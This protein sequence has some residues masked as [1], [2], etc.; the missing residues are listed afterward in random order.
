[1]LLPQTRV[2]ITIDFGRDV[3]LSTYRFEWHSGTSV[4]NG[5]VALWNNS[6]FI[7]SSTG[8][9]VYGGGLGCNAIQNLTFSQIGRYLTF[10]LVTNTAAG[11]RLGIRRVYITGQAL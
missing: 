2:Q 9:T 11:T 7:V 3:L 6:N 5:G 8:Y 10:M 1:M 4:H